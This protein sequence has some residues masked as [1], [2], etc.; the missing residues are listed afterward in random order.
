MHELSI[1]RF[2]LSLGLA[3]AMV[4]LGCATLMLI[5]PEPQVVAFFNSLMHGL[6][7]EPIM[8]WE[9]AWWELIFGVIQTFVLAWLFGA[10]IASIY[11]VAGRLG[12]GKRSDA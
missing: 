7:V 6:D 8:R 11:N 12:T 4:Y 3:A 2:A 10:L 1:G 9:M 5:A